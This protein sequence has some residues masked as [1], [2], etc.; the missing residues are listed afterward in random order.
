MCLNKESKIKKKGI[1][2]SLAYFQKLLK[3]QI[4]LIFTRGLLLPSACLISM[5]SVNSLLSI[6]AP[7]SQHT[8]PK[9]NSPASTAL[10]WSTEIKAGFYATKEGKINI[11]Q[12]GE[13][14]KVFS[15]N[16]RW[17]NFAQSQSAAVSATH[18]QHNTSLCNRGLN[19]AGCQVDVFWL[20]SYIKATLLSICVTLWLNCHPTATTSLFVKRFLF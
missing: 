18:L 11:S 6:T 4:F 10:C 20:Y 7:W 17:W 3:L 2:R 5:F 19:S 16:G 9:Q 8:K 15:T 12:Q 1:P 14:I 13:H